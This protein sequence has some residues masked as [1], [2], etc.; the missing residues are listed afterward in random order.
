[1]TVKEALEILCKGIAPNPTANNECIKLCKSALGKQIP[2][3][4]IEDGYYDEPCVCPTC[5]GDVTNMA[6]NDYHFQH[7]HYCGQ[8]LDWSDTE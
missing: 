5:G 1:M 7:C 3:K 6:D 2:K 8:K 4:P